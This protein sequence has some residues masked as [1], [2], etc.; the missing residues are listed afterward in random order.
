M[1]NSLCAGR[2]IITSAL[3]VAMGMLMLVPAGTVW[4]DIHDNLVVHLTFNGDVMDHTGRGNDGTIM[5]PGADSPYVPGVI[6]QAYQ[7]K[8]KVLGIDNSTS[9]YIT[10]GNPPDLNFDGS[11]DISFSWWGQYTADAQHD[12]IPWLSNK[13]WNS[14]GNRGWVLA[15]EE[16]GKGLRW[17]FRAY[18]EGRMDIPGPYAGVGWDDGMWHHYVVTFTRGANGLATVYQDGAIVDQRPIS[19]SLAI[20]YALLPTNIFQDGT[21]TYTDVSGP[22]G[23]ANFDLASIDDLGIW[24]RALTDDEV[25]L[26]YNMGLKGVSA[27]D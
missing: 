21:G 9:S 26:I 7:T 24:R 15:S 27:L 5:R 18:G 23:G 1:G 13:D 6:G 2:P 16:G 4:A 22:P 12:D 10:L 14:G 11:T 19:S 3:A 8:G 25:T 17:N 20:G